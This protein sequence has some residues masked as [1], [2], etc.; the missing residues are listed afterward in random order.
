[1]VPELLGAGTVDQVIDYTTQNVVN[2]IGRGTV[3]FMLDTA[4]T[5]M[6]SL[7]VLKPKTSFLLTITGKSGQTLV[8]D[9]PTAPWLL[10][11]FADALD[12]FYKWR[13]SRWEIR[14][15]HVFTQTINTDL[16]RLALWLEEG[17]VKAVIGREA[18]VEDLD[19]VRAMAQLVYAG[20]G[21]VGKYVVDFE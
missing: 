14:Y 5:A 11:K 12:S 20:H 6:S 10:L 15:D 7:P 13:A 16:D 17:K 4:L 19:A 1:M 21:G 8:K 18:K 9:W 2:A 3:D